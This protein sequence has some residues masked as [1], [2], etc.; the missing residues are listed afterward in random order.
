MTDRIKQLKSTQGVT[1]TEMLLALLL[2]ALVMSFI[3]GGITVLQNAYTKITLRAEAQT[4]L[5]TVITAVSSELKNAHNIEQL[6]GT[7]WFEN[8]KRGYKMCLYTKDSSKPIYIK[9]GNEVGQEV[10]LFSEKIMTSGLEV[11]LSRIVYD[12]EQKRFTYTIEIKK[13]E[14]NVIEQTI[15]V[16]PLNGT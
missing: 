14:S 16:R 11:T 8:T 6:D 4:L 3:G 9:A 7:Y 2:I 1:M 13:G 12:S 5:S 10:P 15:K